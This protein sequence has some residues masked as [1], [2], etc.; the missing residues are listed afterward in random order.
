M[1]KKRSVYVLKVTEKLVQFMNFNRDHNNC[2]Y[3]ILLLL[4]VSERQEFKTATKQS[5]D[6]LDK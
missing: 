6:K 2:F 5:K 4:I 1:F 3:F